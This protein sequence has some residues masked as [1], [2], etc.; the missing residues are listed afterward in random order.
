MARWA[1]PEWRK[2]YDWSQPLASHKTRL[3]T[4]LLVVA[5]G[6]AAGTAYKFGPWG[7]AGGGGETPKTGSLVVDCKPEKIE[8]TSLPGAPH[9][10]I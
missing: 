7:K 6:L 1:S 10:H 5:L 2:A 8:V 9:R 3:E 4:L